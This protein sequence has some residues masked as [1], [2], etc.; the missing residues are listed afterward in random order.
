L[1]Y[2]YQFFCLSQQACLQLLCRFSV[3]A[4]SAVVAV[5]AVF[6]VAASAVVAA[7]VVA[8]FVVAAF[9]VATSAVVAASAVATSVVFTGQLLFREPGCPVRMCCILVHTVVTDVC[10]FA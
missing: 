1:R 8:A 3:F 6:A 5:V 2:F 7:F 4:A 10:V 9:A